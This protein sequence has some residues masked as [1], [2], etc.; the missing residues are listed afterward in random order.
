VP[1]GKQDF[2]KNADLTKVAAEVSR[3]AQ[4]AAYVAIGLGVLG[5][6][7]AQVRRRDL[8]RQ[9]E[10]LQGRLAA[11]SESSGSDIRTEA[12][13]LLKEFDTAVGEL[14]D[15]LDA[16]LEPVSER[17]PAGAQAALHQAQEARDQLRGYLVSLAA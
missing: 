14:M 17:L 4:D 15:R 10:S 3:A 7:K 8:G 2:L 9:L 13:R 11:L 1:T 6:Q 12:S 16:T 5:F